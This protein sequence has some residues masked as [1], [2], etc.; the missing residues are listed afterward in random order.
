[1]PD[2]APVIAILS[3]LGTQEHY[4]GS[5]KGVITRIAP[6]ARILDLS[7]GVSHCDIA[8]GAQLLLQASVDFPAGTIFLA[9][10]HPSSGAGR[11][12][13]ART[14]DGCLF[15]GP[16]NGLLVM[17]LEKHGLEVAHVIENKEYGY[18]SE[19]PLVFHGRDTLAPAAAH[20]AA[21]LDIAKLGPAAGELHALPEPEAKVED[22]TI[23]G[24]VQRVDYFGNLIT[25]VPNK[26]LDQIGAKAGEGN[27]RIQI[28]DGSALTLP[29]RTNYADAEESGGLTMIDAAGFLQLALNRGS[30]CDAHGGKRGD[31][32]QVA[33]KAS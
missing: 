1:M 7:H 18:K 21:G 29:F 8:E 13:A 3:D 28:A 15:V 24:I 16:D 9:S 33:W 14:Q 22:D 32:V 12:I 20:L 23:H 17:A 30:F 5:M 26:L 31:K 10:V 11:A 25:S 4:V 2:S 27:L 19:S 6:Q